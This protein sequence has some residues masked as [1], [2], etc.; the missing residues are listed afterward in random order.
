MSTLREMDNRI[1]VGEIFSRKQLM[2]MFKIS[3]QSGIMK[4]NALNCLV[5]ITSENNGVYADSGIENGTIMYTGE[6]LRGDQQLN[7]NNKSIYESKQT[8][9]PMYLFSK[10][11]ARNYI[12]EGKVELCGVPYQI[13]EKD[14]EGND[15][16]VW[17]F[18]LK[19]I[20]SEDVD[21]NEDDRLQQVANEVARIEE[22]IIKS[23]QGIINE[24]TIFKQ[25][26]KRLLEEGANEQVE[27]VD[28]FFENK[29]RK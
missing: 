26:R 11:K 28:E 3:G 19:I 6:G 2:E 24:T 20:Y 5:L 9:L 14:K 17:K 23:K 13:T 21:L 22:E 4:T 18:P 16:L 10:D 1:N 27:K 7:K 8:G 15:R 12:F 29:K 25:E